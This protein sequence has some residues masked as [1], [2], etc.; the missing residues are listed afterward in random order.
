MKAWSFWDL[1]L[2]NYS[3]DLWPHLLKE[4]GS[5]ASSSGDHNQ[6]GC[7]VHLGSSSST[8]QG[9]VSESQAADTHTSCVQ[10]HW[11]GVHAALTALGGNCL[12]N[13]ED[14]RGKAAP[15]QQMNTNFETVVGRGVYT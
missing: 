14:K 9:R 12:C 3:H 15:A 1:H 10:F 8:D 5:G 13:S 6:G 7:G 11:A 2:K 4:K